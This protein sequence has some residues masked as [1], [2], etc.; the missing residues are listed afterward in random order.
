MKE[1]WP[2]RRSQVQG[3]RSAK[4]IGVEWAE[5]SYLG[6]QERV[7]CV[8]V[9]VFTNYLASA[10]TPMVTWD[11]MDTANTTTYCQMVGGASSDSAAQI[12][13]HFAK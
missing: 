1:L 2:T 10:F 4:I 9:C 5:I 13:V 6:G 3:Q 11:K 7:V 8:C 12:L